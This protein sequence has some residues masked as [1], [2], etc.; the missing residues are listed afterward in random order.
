MS[1]LKDIYQKYWDGYF[2]H[3]RNNPSIEPANPFLIVEPYDYRNKTK[4]VMICGQETQCWGEKEFGDS[5]DKATLDAILGIYAGFVNEKRYNS[6]Y[7]Q[8]INSLKKACPEVGF[9][10]NNIVKIGKKYGAGC[11]DRI[12]ELTLKYFPVIPEELAIL[13]PDMIL[14]LTGPKYDWRI[15]KALGDFKT[16]QIGNINCFDEIIF[17]DSSLPKAI[18]CYHPRYLRQCGQEKMVKAFLISEFNKF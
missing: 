12:N 16:K 10:C 7:W 11:D 15:R 2:T 8:F 3:I 17:D 18:R 5:P 6:P 9:V 4:K 1:T 13:K 14:F